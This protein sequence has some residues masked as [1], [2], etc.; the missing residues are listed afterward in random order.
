MDLIESDL[1]NPI[2]HWYYQHKFWF[3][4]KSLRDKS[5]TVSSLVD[6]GAGSALFSKELV[7][8]GIIESVVAVDTGY[9]NEFDDTELK[10]AFRK[11]ARFENF[12]YFLLT[13]I[14]EHIDSDEIFLTE[15]VKEADP[16]SRFIFTVPAHMSLWSSHDVFLKHFR[17]Y[18]KSELRKLLSS[19]GLEIDSIRYIYSTVFL[20]AFAQRR[21][22]G[23]KVPRSQLRSHGQGVSFFMRL[24]LIPDRWISFL[25]FGVSI[26]ATASKPK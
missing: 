9:E 14:L 20:L 16:G 19:S 15:I 22:F 12:C 23:R 4:K 24:Q 11:S 17:R 1:V 5:L 2:T 21:F 26:F 10:I 25:P 13:D 6:I 7:R 8:L 3:I 18:K